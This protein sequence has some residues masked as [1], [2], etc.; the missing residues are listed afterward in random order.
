MS[1]TTNSS[2]LSGKSTT[3][4]FDIIATSLTVNKDTLIKGDLTVLGNTNIG[5][6]TLENA[7][8]DFLTVNN[9]TA[10]NP[11]PITSGGTGLSTIGAPNQVLTVNPGGT[12]L[13]YQPP[14]LLN[15]ATLTGLGFTGTPTFNFGIESTGSGTDGKG[16]V[17]TSSAAFGLDISTQGTGKY[18]KLISDTVTLPTTTTPSTN[19]SSGALVVSGDVGI[20][21][22]INLGSTLNTPAEITAASTY[23]SFNYVADSVNLGPFGLPTSALLSTGRISM[24][25][26]L[27]IPTP[28]PFTDN[29]TLTFQPAGGSFASFGFP[30]YDLR[31]SSGSVNTNVGPSTPTSLG[32]TAQINN[33]VSSFENVLSGVPIPV[34]SRIQ[35]VNN[36]YQAG[37]AFGGSAVSTLYTEFASGA[38]I[39]ELNAT[40]GSGGIGTAGFISLL[41]SGGLLGSQIRIATTG[42]NTNG[43]L[44]NP[45][46][47]G[48]TISPSNG[49]IILSP[50]LVLNGNKNSFTSGILNI[51]NATTSAGSNIAS[52]LNPNLPNNGTTVITIGKENNVNSAAEL[53]YTYST[54]PNNSFSTWS[55]YGGT[56][57]NIILR[58]NQSIELFGTINAKIIQLSTF[59]TSAGNDLFTLDPIN[60]QYR[61]HNSGGSHCLSLDR[62]YAF[63]TL[64][65]NTVSSNTKGYLAVSVPNADGGNILSLYNEG[66]TDNSLLSKT[67]GKDT[68]TGNSILESFQF[69]SN[70]DYRNLYSARFYGLADFM[71]VQKGV[72]NGAFNSTPQISFNAHVIIQNYL[73]SNRAIT[74]DGSNLSSSYTWKWPSDMGTNGQFLTTNGTNTLSWSSELGSTTINGRLQIFNSLLSADFNSAFCSI[75]GTITANTGGT[76]NVLNI[77]TGLAGQPYSIA[78]FLM[79]SMNTQVTS[80]IHFG[81]TCNAGNI[82]TSG[83][84]SYYYDSTI[85]NAKITLGFYGITN[86]AITLQNNGTTSIE[87]PNTS[88]T[89]ITKFLLPNATTT[90]NSSS[91]ILGQ[92]DSLNASTFLAYVY[93]ST[94]SNS[95]AIWG[96]SGSS[97]PNIT[98][99]A[100]G[101]AI[102]TGNTSSFTDSVFITQ[103]TSP[104]PRFSGAFLAPN[105]TTNKIITVG[106]G[107]DLSLYNTMELSFTSNGTSSYGMFSMYGSSTYINQRTNG[108]INIIGTPD[109][110]INGNHRF[111]NTG[112][113]GFF[114]SA[115]GPQSSFNTRGYIYSYEQFITRLT[116][117]NL[118]NFY[119]SNGATVVGNINTNGSNL[120]INSTYDSRL[121]TNIQPV[122]NILSLIEQIEPVSFTWKTNSSISEIGFIAD[123]LY[124]VIP[125]LTTGTPNKITEDGKPEYMTVSYGG[126]S[127]Y[128]VAAIQELYSKIKILE[129]KVANLENNSSL[130]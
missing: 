45:A 125:A 106:I 111:T 112:N 41:A 23:T 122:S 83:S 93:N 28:F 85:A 49:G 92:A 62:N 56:G 113:A 24:N 121:K 116:S 6:V 76:L 90:G 8:V 123:D 53:S 103:N 50:E 26:I 29:S 31:L 4:A 117:G 119:A 20:G 99:K 94:L 84:L 120:T 19:T 87:S 74:F 96:F 114:T 25:G 55:F 51:N 18:L 64:P 33:T 86:P 124:K 17:R 65:T 44:I 59:E 80:S 104:D 129:T 71:T 3:N 43:V 14:G 37:V 78:T 75:T 130:N 13:T 77:F 21:G 101:S 82:G 10:T 98:L 89:V 88:S 67:F 100:S 63:F 36:G 68:V 48:V 105:M 72:N 30:S 5:T 11:I 97:T 127:P 109:V 40:G 108:E 16:F 126:F 46:S 79:P 115:G 12:A 7:N 9:L 47:G 81:R 91:I 107:K 95:S 32:I 58:N 34:S 22:K 2:N 27:N 39:I 35:N 42:A 73:P 61:F 52:F 69:Y 110:F 70:S 60:F 57:S 15:P 118:I 38:Q 1:F 66:L 128:L 102:L 54:T